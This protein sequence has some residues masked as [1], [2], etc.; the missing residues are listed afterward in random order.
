MRTQANHD[1]LGV[2]AIAQPT[3]PL[4]RRTG[5]RL[6]AHE[7]HVC[8]RHEIAIVW[9]VQVC[10]RMDVGCHRLARLLGPCQERPGEIDIAQDGQLAPGQRFLEEPHRIGALLNVLQIHIDLAP[11][12]SVEKNHRLGCLRQDVQNV[13]AGD[14]VGGHGLQRQPACRVPPDQRREGRAI[15]K[16]RQ[17]FGDVVTHTG[18][19][20]I[21]SEKRVAHRT[22]LDGETVDTNGC[23]DIDKPRNQDIGHWHRSYPPTAGSRMKTVWPSTSAGLLDEPAISTLTAST[24]TP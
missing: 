2:V 9:V 1:H 4:L 16:S 6:I 19:T 14:A 20:A 10:N 22:V 8:R 3:D 12:S 13:S 17:G 7:E 21:D 15:A 18:R 5:Q 24:N 11:T 23:L